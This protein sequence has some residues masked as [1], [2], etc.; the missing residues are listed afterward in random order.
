MVVTFLICRSPRGWTPVRE[1]SSS[2]DRTREQQ[3]HFQLPSNRRLSSHCHMVRVSTFPYLLL[4]LS[5][6]VE[7]DIIATHCRVYRGMPLSQSMKYMQRSAGSDF[8]L[9]VGRTKK[10]EDEGEYFVRAE[11]SFGRKESNTYL[12]IEM[13]RETT[14][15]K[16][17]Q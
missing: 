5:S 9:R 15:G 13:V 11:N 8:S 12:I 2:S 4:A 3:R 17:Q 14:E 10:S 7:I 1:T 16:K 6:N